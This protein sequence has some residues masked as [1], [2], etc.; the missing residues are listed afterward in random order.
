[1]LEEQSLA[2]R[3]ITFGDDEF[4]VSK[5][6]LKGHITYG[7]ALFIK[8]SGYSE[9]ELLG[10]PHNILRHEDMPKTIFKLLWQTIQSKNEI[11]A[12]V[13][14]RTKEGDYYWVEANVTPSL[15]D[16]GNIIGYHSVRRKPSR[17]QLD[18]IEPLYKK[19][20]DEE[21]RGG[22]EAGIRYINE[23]LNRQGVGYEQ[24]ILSI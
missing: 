11:T 12:F 3:E 22:V 19:L 7:N 10:A 21:R 24:F 4:I 20:L 16:S 23:L 2:G 8:M 14:N 6:D 13:K 15:D 5:T 18:T 9:K 17:K 1:M